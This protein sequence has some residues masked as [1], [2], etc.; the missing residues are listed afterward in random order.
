[1]RKSDAPAG[2]D[3]LLREARRLAP[4]LYA[5]AR[6][7][8]QGGI[9]EAGLPPLPGGRQQPSLPWAKLPAFMKALDDMPGLGALAFFAWALTRVEADFAGRAFAAYGGV[10]IAASLGWMWA[11]EGARPDRWDVAGAALCLAGAAL[12][13]FAPRQA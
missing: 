9:T 13:L 11:V 4:A 8:R 10:Y 2:R 6:V 7:L 5:L 3:D 1:M 12:I